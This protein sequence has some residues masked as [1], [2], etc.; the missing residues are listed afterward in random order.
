M[1]SRKRN[2]NIITK[3]NAAKITNSTWTNATGQSNV[4]ISMSAI[5]I[6]SENNKTSNA[7]R[8]EVFTDKMVLRTGDIHAALSDFSIYYTWKNIKKYTKTN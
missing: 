1:N 6:N 3:T 8:L 5:L 7:C 4:N 2:Q